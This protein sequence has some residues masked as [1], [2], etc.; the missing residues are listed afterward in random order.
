M[1]E[2]TAQEISDRDSKYEEY[3][4]IKPQNYSVGFLHMYTGHKV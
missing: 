2:Y 3:L 4:G 1:K